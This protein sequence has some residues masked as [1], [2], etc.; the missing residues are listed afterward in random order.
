MNRKV[1]DTIFYIIVGLL[2]A[3]FML[4]LIV[5]GIY[6]IAG[7]GSRVVIDLRNFFISL[8]NTDATFVKYSPYIC[9]GS[10]IVLT[11]ILY[12]KFNTRIN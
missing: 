3:L 6:G 12:R 11:F 4:A 8:G 7:A 10:G 2:V 9:V 5:G 1:K